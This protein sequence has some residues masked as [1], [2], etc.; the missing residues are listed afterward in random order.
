M[1]TRLTS[2]TLAT[3]LTLA[4]GAVPALAT[5]GPGTV[6]GSTT[7][8]LGER[9]RGPGSG[10]GRGSGGSG[11]GP[12]RGGWVVGDDHGS[13]R[14]GNDDAGAA[15]RPPSPDR[16]SSPSRAAGPARA[17]AT[18]SASAL[19]PPTPAASAAPELAPPVG[20]VADRQ[21][22]FPRLSTAPATAAVAGVV[23]GALLLAG[24]VA[25]GFR[26]R[27]RLGRLG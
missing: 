15:V 1:R 9:G 21:A 27:A 22:G 16:S 2:L 23:G 25:A 24:M 20:R 11:P 12:R 5:P 10:E 7:H 4:A 14:R 26:A 18:S 8:T 19:A 17:P 6:D 3:L 13:G